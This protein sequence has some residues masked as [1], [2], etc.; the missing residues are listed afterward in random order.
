MFV[1]SAYICGRHDVNH[2]LHYLPIL[3][4]MQENL[5]TVAA[6]AY[7][8]MYVNS[9]NLRI[10]LALADM[11]ANVRRSC[12]V[13]CPGQRVPAAAGVEVRA[14]QWERLA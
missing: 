12:D 9:T 6:R 1:R 10:T 7:K 3:R 4:Q 11:A 5:D 2:A 14:V 13:H 8:G